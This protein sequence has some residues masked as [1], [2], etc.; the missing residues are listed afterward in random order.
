M[1]YSENKLLEF[2]KKAIE[3]VSQ[4]CRI[5]ELA[6]LTY[7]IFKLPLIVAD[8]GYRLI[9]YA[10][11][12]NIHDPYWQ[13]IIYSGEPTD[14]TIMKFYIDD[15][16]MEAITGSNEAIYIDWGVCVD[17]PQTCGPIYIDNNLEGFVSILFMREELL[18]FSLKLNNLLRQFCAILM[19][20]NNYRLTHAIN[21]VKELLA[22]KF[23]DIENYVDAASL[24]D[25]LKIVQLKAS[26]C[27][28]VL[29]QKNHDSMLFSRLKSQIVK[30]CQNLLYYEKEQKLY[31]LFHQLRDSKLSPAFL[32]LI[33][34]SEC[35]CGASTVFDS[36]DQRAVFIQ[37][38]E[39]ARDTAQSLNTS[40]QCIAFSECL[41]EAFLLHPLKAFKKE[42]LMPEE[43]HTLF[44]Y[45]EVHETELAKTLSV[46]L[47]LRNDINKTAKKLHV[48]R[49]TLIYRLNKIRDLAGVEIDDPEVAWRFQ[50]IFGVLE[51]STGRK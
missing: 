28:V 44:A 9:A 2:T 41:T 36:L 19:Q 13:Q 1:E 32:Q 8:P 27:I 40:S 23:F 51:V 4:G 12:E 43:I 6:Q 37:Q 38:A 15:G 3:T 33:R 50:L 35:Y 7:Q 26:Y 48:H 11:G 29:S 24:E 42:N 49:N 47:Q 10:G 22:Q 14:H 18:E 16:L 30:E 46:Y 17:Y 5:E 34:Q 21:P 45:D 31:L 20:S 39:I 25:Y